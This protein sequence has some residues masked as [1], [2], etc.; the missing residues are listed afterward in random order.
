MANTA[1]E[2]GG[3]NYLSE[4]ALIAALALFVMLSGAST[5]Q[6]GQA[7]KEHLRKPFRNAR[8]AIAR[9]YPDLRA[10]LGAVDFGEWHLE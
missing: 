6:A 3:R 5:R 10:A 4:N 1:R 9:D 8:K 7:L 2:S